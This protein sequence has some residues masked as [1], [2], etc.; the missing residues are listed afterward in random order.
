VEEEEGGGGGL[1]VEVD[2]SEREG[3]REGEMGSEEVD[4]PKIE[5]MVDSGVFRVL[6]LDN[7]VQNL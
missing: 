5:T 7:G 3:E 4:V 1:S 6:Q 2:S